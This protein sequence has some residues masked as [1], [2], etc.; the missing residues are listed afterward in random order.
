MNTQ[1]PITYLIGGYF[2]QDW[3]DDYTTWEEAI[4]DFVATDR[5]TAEQAPPAIRALLQSTD[6]SGLTDICNQIDGSWN[7]GRIAGTYTR[8]FEMILDRIEAQLRLQAK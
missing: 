7:F 5:S 8:W 6:E 4:D 3:T 1:D 2:H